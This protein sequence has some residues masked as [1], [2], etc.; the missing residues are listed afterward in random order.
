MAIRHDEFG[1]GQKATRAVTVGR[2]IGEYSVWAKSTKARKCTT[3]AQC[4]ET[5]CSRSAA[6][7]S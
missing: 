2:G 5:Y 7:S 3:R 4:L 1:I 6:H